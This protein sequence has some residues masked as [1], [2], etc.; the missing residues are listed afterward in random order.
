MD[1]IWQTLLDFA[2]TNGIWALLF[3][4]LL[5]YQLKDSRAREK[6]YQS[7]IDALSKGLD[8]MQDI[9]VNIERIRQE[10]RAKL[11]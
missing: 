2:A 1:N 10:M 9:D 5:I 7:T 4:S 6:K 11:G 3:C 8:Y